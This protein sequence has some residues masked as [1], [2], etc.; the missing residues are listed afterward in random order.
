MIIA[1]NVKLNRNTF[2]NITINA[3]GVE[4]IQPYYYK[5]SN[6]GLSEKGGQCDPVRKWPGLLIGA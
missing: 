5:R 2:S 4:I 1:S 6:I 3:I